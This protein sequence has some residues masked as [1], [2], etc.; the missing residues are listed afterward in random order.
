MIVAIIFNIFFPQV[1]KTVGATA[2][3][4]TTIAVM[5]AV[6]LAVIGLFRFIFIHE[7]VTEQ[8]DRREQE[9]AEKKI[10][11]RD[12]SFVQ[13]VKLMFKNKYTWLLVGM[14][15]LAMMVAA[16]TAETMDYGEWKN[17][18]RIEGPL[19][20]IIAFSQ[21]VGPAIASGV[22]GLIMGIAG[23]DGLAEVQSA[24][25]NNA[26]VL[27]YNWIPIVLLIAA[28]VFAF[29]WQLGKLMPKIQTEL[30]ERRN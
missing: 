1:V 3:G 4:W 22:T 16:Y 2:G 29:M 14:V 9:G 30:E 21:K 10:S 24:S 13:M 12:L 8:E 28:T 20:S 5:M 23:Y 15:P 18:I 17:G 25:A 7:I 27:L 26:I 6:P 11:G 19:N